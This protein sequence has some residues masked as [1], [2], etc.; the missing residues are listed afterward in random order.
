M[1]ARTKPL[2]CA[3]CGSP[4]DDVVWSGHQLLCGRCDMFVNYG[5]AEPDGEAEH[6]GRGSKLKLRG[7]DLARVRP[8]RWAWPR[9]WPIGY[10]AL[11]IGAEGVGKGTLISHLVA[12]LTRGTLPGD[13]EGKPTTVAFIGDEDSFDAVVTPRLHA[14][15]ADLERVRTTE[16]GVDVERDA[17]ALGDLVDDEGIGAVIFDQLLDNLGEGLDDWR[18]KPI[19]DALRP[20]RRVARERDIAVLAALHPTRGRRR[21]SWTPTSRGRRD[22]DAPRAAIALQWTCLPAGR[23]GSRRVRWQRARAKPRS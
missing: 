9:R 17:G 18:A 21:A 6:N 5:G 7:V 4:A 2:R 8:V 3:H 14:A 16:E 20:L 19:R 22:R 12:H 1:S 13:L 10:L 23:D 15:G 11:L